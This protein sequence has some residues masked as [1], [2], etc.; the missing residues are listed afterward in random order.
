MV[1]NIRWFKLDINK[2]D[3][4][5]TME[6]THNCRVSEGT[7]LPDEFIRGGHSGGL[8]ERSVIVAGGNNWSKDKTTKYWL[9][10]SLFFR[11]GRWD[12]WPDLPKPLA[13]SM[14]A[15]DKNGLY[16]A[17]GTVDGTLLS[18]DTYVLNSLKEGSV[19]KELPQLPKALA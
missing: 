10:N 4:K 5:N 18:A 11:D 16:I 9:K 1:S 2:S 7:P 12:A 14:Y 8:V 15:H 17:G 6:N 3:N 13:Y 19:W